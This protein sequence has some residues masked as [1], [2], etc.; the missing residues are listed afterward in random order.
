[1]VADVNH[2]VFGPVSPIAAV[3]SAFLGCLD[4]IIL[5]TKAQKYTGRRRVRLLLYGSVA[6]G[7]T[8]VWQ[9]N[10]L[11]MLGLDVPDSVVRFN[12]IFALISLGVALA[13]IT[14]GLFVASYGR[15][16]FARLVVAGALLGGGVAGTNYLLLMSVEVGGQITYSLALMPLSVALATG[17]ASVLLRFLVGTRRMRSAL[18]AAVGMGVAICA[19]HY[20]GEAALQ[21]RLGAAGTAGGVAGVSPMLIALPTMVLGAVLIVM[22][23]FFTV[24]TATRR[25]MGAIFDPLDDAGQ[26]EPWMIEEVTARI[27]LTTTGE[28]PA[29]TRIA[30]A[31]GGPL[32]GR[33]APAPRP[34][35][36]ITP[37][38]RVMPVWG[39]PDVAPEPESARAWALRNAITARRTEPS[40]SGD[41]TGNSRR[42]EMPV[43]SVVPVSPAPVDAD[44]E[45]VRA[46]V[47]A[48]P[49]SPEGAAA[50][51]DAP[52]PRRNARR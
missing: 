15:I 19:V 48:G 30:G 3:V 41:R 25:D 42:A 46:Y 50:A 52:L 20:V 35:P 21:I 45:V 37:V 39:R 17:V 5:A 18:L 2:F 32:P 36:G 14:A 10:I 44:P 28:Q 24:G 11:A 38:W 27:A 49:G 26:I 33:L 7:V 8:G 29:I 23:W 51:A 22:M 12:P 6:I 40:S 13:T 34:T 47:P 1:M 4:G 9:A 31:F 16:T 43:P